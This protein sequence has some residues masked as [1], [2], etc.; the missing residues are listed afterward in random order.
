MA[1]GRTDDPAEPKA[2][3]ALLDFLRSKGRLDGKSVATTELILDKQTVRADVVLCNPNALH[4]FE[5]KTERDTLARL[6]RQ[7]EIY[8]KHADFV[9]VVAATRHINAVI[10]RVPEQVGI[11]EMVTFSGASEIR[12]LREAQQSPAFDVNAMLSFLPVTELRARLLISSRSRR[13]EAIAEAVALPDVSKKAAVLSFL[14]ERYGPN[15]S[16][17]LRATKRRKIQPGDLDFLKRWRQAKTQC[18]NTPKVCLSDRSNDLD[19]EVYNF[20][21]RSF[22]PV[23]DELRAL[24]AS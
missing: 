12:I 1:L 13:E 2:K 5:I 17:L 16:A 4:C 8:A 7:L 19:Q 9:T 10:S 6:D 11:Y 24:L 20:V 3:A 22:G 14:C 21:G 18:D 23:P 15:S